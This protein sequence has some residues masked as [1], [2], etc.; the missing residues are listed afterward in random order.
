MGHPQTAAL[1]VLNQG[2]LLVSLLYRDPQ[3]PWGAPG[4]RSM[5]PH[6]CREPDSPAASRALPPC[7]V[8]G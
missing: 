3:H 5:A 2:M 8:S 7:S 1:R 6:G 4:V